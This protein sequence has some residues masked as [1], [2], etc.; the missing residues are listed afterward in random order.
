MSKQVLLSTRAQKEFRGLSRSMKR[1]VKESLSKL[2]K[3]DMHLDI[4]KLK[5]VGD[6][7]DLY[8]LR[9]GDHRIVYYP[10][11]KAIKVI[12]IDRRDKIYD[13]LE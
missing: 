6:R 3:G 7:E 9:V 1:R 13:W 4:K 8:R 11:K 12:R 5:G 10:E 2:S